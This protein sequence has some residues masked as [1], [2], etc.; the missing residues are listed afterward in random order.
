MM[1]LF[2]SQLFEDTLHVDKTHVWVKLQT[3]RMRYSMSSLVHDFSELDKIFC[4]E[5]KIQKKHEC[6][7]WFMISLLSQN[8]IW[9]SFGEGVKFK[10]NLLTGKLICLLEV[11]TVVAMGRRAFWQD[12]F[13]HTT[14]FYLWKQICCRL[15]IFCFTDSWKISLNFA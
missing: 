6:D 1:G 12:R 7:R 15:L 11:C 4:L 9:Q 3:W 14:F 5:K 13:S 2:I 10:F 8:F